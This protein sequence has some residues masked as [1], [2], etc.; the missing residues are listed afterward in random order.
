MTSEVYRRKVDTRDE[1]LSLI[2]DF[3]VRIKERQDALRQ[4]IRHVFARAAEC[5][6][7]LTVKFSQIYFIR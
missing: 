5:T 6:L 1:L 3:V 7:M 2:M 4:E